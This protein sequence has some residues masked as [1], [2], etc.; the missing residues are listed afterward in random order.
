MVKKI[1]NQKEFDQIIIDLKKIEGNK[2]PK[3]INLGG[4]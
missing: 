2:K 3:I 1:V 4:N